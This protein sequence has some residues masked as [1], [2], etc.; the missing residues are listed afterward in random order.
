VPDPFVQLVVSNVFI[1]T[2]YVI[3]AVFAIPRFTGMSLLT[4][5]FGFGFLLLCGILNHFEFVAHVIDDARL[6][7]LEVTSPHMVIGHNAQA[8]CSLGFVGSIARDLAR[9]RNPFAISD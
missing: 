7:E 4:K 6:S 2:G 9:G 3:A 8:L 1:G 5:L